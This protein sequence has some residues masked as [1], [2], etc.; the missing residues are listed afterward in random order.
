MIVTSIYYC[1]YLV[2]IVVV[3]GYANI[4][5]TNHAIDVTILIV[6]LQ[7][8]MSMI[9]IVIIRCLSDSK[10]LAVIVNIL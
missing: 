10:V 4:I 9:V 7:D 1:R 5:I 6:M 3:V 2:V 8:S